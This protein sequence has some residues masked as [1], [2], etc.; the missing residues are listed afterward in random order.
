[1]LSLVNLKQSTNKFSGGDK[2]QSASQWFGCK[3]VVS[4]RLQALQQQTNY[5][6]NVSLSVVSQKSPRVDDRRRE[7]PERLQSS[8]RY[9]GAVPCAT[10]NIRTHN[11][12]I[13]RLATGLTRPTLKQLICLFMTKSNRIR[14]QKEYVISHELLTRIKWECF[15]YRTIAFMHY[16]DDDLIIRAYRPC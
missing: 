16:M 11:L 4:S 14:A 7:S 5:P 9:A 12:Y 2:K 3:L 10:S 1:M 6:R 8:V 15:Q 13:M